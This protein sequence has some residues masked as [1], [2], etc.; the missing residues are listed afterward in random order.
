MIR[1]RAQGT[2]ARVDLF[3][4]HLV[5][6]RHGGVFGVPREHMIPLSSIKSVALYR[7]KFPGPGRI[8]LFV[9][10]GGSRHPGKLG[11]D[12]TIFFGRSQLAAFEALHQAI[13][14]A[15]ATPSLEQ[16]AM[17]AQ[18]S[19]A[20]SAISEG[21]PQ[22]KPTRA[23]V[24]RIDGPQQSYNPNTGTDYDDLGNRGHQAYHQGGQ[25]NAEYAPP[26]GSWWSDMPLLGKILL[27]GFLL[28]LV[29]MCASSG[30]HSA[31]APDPQAPVDAQT[32]EAVVNPGPA[33]DG[34]PDVHQLVMEGDSRACSHPETFEVVRSILLSDDIRPDSFGVSRSDLNLAKAKARTVITQVTVD[35]MRPDIHEITCAG[36]LD[37]GGDDSV[38]ITYSLRPSAEQDGQVLVGLADATALRASVLAGPLTEIRNRH[39]AA[40]AAAANLQ[41]AQQAQQAVQNQPQAA[42][43]ADD[44]Y[45]P[46]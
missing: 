19:R 12:N 11:D 43:N 3:E 32:T 26:P 29:A 36:Q 22:A 42:P 7:P 38:P 23:V 24:E 8:V 17:A 35:A 2:G 6:D 27:I 39:A 25:H 9:E 28:L 10:S 18:R 37:Y 1:L 44:L 16:M 20:Q 14:E 33:A 21:R 13:R 45:A 31:P 15:I 4:H 41:Q 30:D 40:E 46:H 34:L 5:V